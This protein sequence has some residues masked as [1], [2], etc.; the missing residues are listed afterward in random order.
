M[1]KLY[2]VLIETS[3]NQNYIFST[4]K[5]KENIGASELTYQAGT[6]WIVKAVAT[7]TKTRLSE[8][9]QEPE[10]FRK[11]LEGQSPI[12]QP[13]VVA[14]IIV[15]ASGK[16][17]I[18]AKTEDVARSII[19][20]V[21]KTALKK[22]PGLDL[23]G[24][25]VEIKDWQKQGSLGA[26]IKE[27]HQVFE[28]QRSHRPSPES[29]FLRLPIIAD[30]AMSGL[31][32]YRIET[33]IG[34]EKPKAISRVS[35]SKRDSQVSQQVIKRLQSIA[36]GTKLVSNINQ[37]ESLFEEMSW[38]AIV[39]ADGNG[40]GQ[41]FL[42]F[43][44]Y[45]GDENRQYLDQYRR[46]S[47]ALDR[48]TEEAFRRAL[49]VLPTDKE[50]LPIVPLIIG[51][52][53]LTV[54]CHGQYALEFTQVFLK[55]FERQTTTNKVISKI[56]EAAFGVG[57]LSACAGV[58]IVKRHFPFSAAY[59]LAE[60]LIK[61]AKEVKTKVTNP[62]KAN[63]PYPCSAIDFH[64]L[65][66][67]SGISLGRIRKK[68]EP[69]A[70]IKLYN[71]P[72]LVTD[73]LKTAT[74][75]AWVDCHRWQR[76]SD[77]VKALSDGGLPMGQANTLRMALFLGKEAADAEYRLIQQRYLDLTTFEEAEGSLFHQYQ[78]LYSTSFLDALD[79]KDFL[80]NHLKKHPIEN[81]EVAP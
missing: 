34:T 13:E 11:W 58:A 53:D 65:Y 57:R 27:A 80:E 50:V 45:A 30:C 38:L 32:A 20:D 69:Q 40:L 39:H 44:Q 36:P 5:L 75:Q 72:Y 8:N 61:S 17:L 4:N 43:S 1:T 46:F 14:E 47:L 71:R 70:H 81:V 2:L 18:L 33:Q 54:V 62:A 52:D 9:W 6:Q 10:T 68:L 23:S 22:A 35:D 29:R 56:A 48:C 66:D 12:D 64:I 7:Q 79:A 51:G 16:S 67:T 60:G 31:P 42:D 15:A 73:D 63:Q 3:G 24:V 49:Q 55:E 41:I 28:E 25:Y 19:A 21:T 26:A 37:L 76:L 74:D 78:D 59:G 77:R